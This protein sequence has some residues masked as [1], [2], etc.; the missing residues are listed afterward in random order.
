MGL[1]YSSVAGARRGGRRDEK[2]FLIVSRL[3]GKVA[4]VTGASMGIGEAIAR[5]FA[6]EGARVALAAR[7]VGKLEAVARALPTEALVVPADVSQPDQV[8]AMVARTIE[9]FGRLDILVNNAAVGMYA[10]VAEMKPE[11]FE[12]LVATNYLG[13]VHAIQAAV[14]QMRKQGGGTIVNISSVAGKVAIPWMGAYC[15]SK[16]ALNALSSSLRMELRTENIHVVIV[17]PGRVRT[18]F[19]KNA[20]K[21]FATRPLYPGGISADR[22]A[23]AVLRAVLRRRREIVVPADNRLLGWIHGLFPGLVDRV[24]VMVLRPQMRKV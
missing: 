20:Y 23:L 5:R 17:C 6:A 1:L 24:M 3:D 8:R 7:S 9:Y 15:S 18:P 19:T 14:P 11:Q 10:S 22:V 12:H 16:F 2:G 4:L 21:D 13:P